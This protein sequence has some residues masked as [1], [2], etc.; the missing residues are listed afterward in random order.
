MSGK[1]EMLELR[2]DEGISRLSGCSNDTTG[3]THSL[4]ATTTTGRTWGPHGDHK[5]DAT[6]SLRSSP[7]ADNLT[8]RF[9]SGDQTTNKKILRWLS[10]Y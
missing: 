10:S 7:D 3:D 8:L 1:E 6:T 2:S 5:P 9:I 4:E